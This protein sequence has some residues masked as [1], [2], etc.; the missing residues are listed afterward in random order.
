MKYK[1]CNWLV[2]SKDI[3]LSIS[4]PPNTSNLP[5]CFRWQ[6]CLKCGSCSDLI[7]R[8]QAAGI[9]PV[10]KGVTLMVRCHHNL[11]WVS[12][13]WCGAIPSPE[14]WIQSTVSWVSTAQPTMR[15]H[16]HE[17]LSFHW[18]PPHQHRQQDLLL[19]ASKDGCGQ[20]MVDFL[21]DLGSANNQTHEH[22]TSCYFFLNYHLYDWYYSLFELQQ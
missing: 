14:I 1:L 2:H 17:W 3:S 22:T 10:P 16:I 20:M 4:C 9:P 19:T 6:F 15:K 12:Y 11:H 18:V 13:C 5:V 8:Q 21:S 7:C